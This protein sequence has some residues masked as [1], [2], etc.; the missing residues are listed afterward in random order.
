M[1][2]LYTHIMQ[3]HRDTRTWHIYIYLGY[4]APGK[5]ETRNAPTKRIGASNCALYLLSDVCAHVTAH[6]A[7]ESVD[8]ELTICG[9]GC[10]LVEGENVSD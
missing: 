6:L 2:V 4:A 8:K 1:F 9:F 5:Y 3:S 7:S 10:Y